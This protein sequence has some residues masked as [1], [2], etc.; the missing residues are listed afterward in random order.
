MPPSSTVRSVAWR[1]SIEGDEIVVQK[2][3]AIGRKAKST[4]E[5]VTP[6]LRAINAA[7]E[8]LKDSLSEAADHAGI[9][10]SAL[11]ALGPTGL[12]AAAA[13]G[14]LALAAHEAFSQTRE[15]E[16]FA[17]TVEKVA[18]RLR[19]GVEAYQEISQG[20][21]AFNIDQGQVDAGLQQL[22]GSIDQFVAGVSGGRGMSR[23]FKDLGLTREQLAGAGSLEAQLNL[24]AD[25]LSRV[26]NANVREGL[27]DRLG[28][29]DLLPMLQE[30][31]AGIDRLRQSA[32]AAG[33][34]M[35]A[36]LVRQGAEANRQIEDLDRKVETR[37]HSSFVGLSPVL[38]GLK[39]LL[40]DMA[41]TVGDMVQSLL[42]VDSKS[43]DFMR[44][45][46][47]PLN[48]TI[49]K[50]QPL[51]DEANRRGQNDATAARARSILS[52]ALA[53]RDA[54]M[55]EIRKRVLDSQQ[56]SPENLAA[57][58][59]VLG[60]SN[61]P[62]LPPSV[63]DEQLNAKLEEAQAKADSLA[64]RRQQAI[65]QLAARAQSAANDRV[66]AEDAA[67]VEILRNKAGYYAALF[68]QSDD[69]RDG[70]IASIKAEEQV[71]LD[72]LSKQRVE[73][74]NLKKTFDDLGKTMPGYQKALDDIAA[75]EARV[76][77]SSQDRV[78]A[79]AMENQ[80]RRVS[81]AREAAGALS[82]L[83]DR[84]NGPLKEALQNVGATELDSFTE[85]LV[86]IVTN[87]KD[88]GRAITDMVTSII[89]DFARLALQR[90]VE[91]P[92]AG[93]LDA[94]ISGMFKG[95]GHAPGG[96]VRAGVTYPV[97]ERGGMPE[98][99]FTPA[100]D[101]YVLSS[102]SS[103]DNIVRLV[104]QR[105][106]AGA[107]VIAPSAPPKVEVHNHGEPMD[108]SQ[109]YDAP[110]NTTR[111][112]LKKQLGDANSA[113]V[114]RGDQDAAMNDRYGVKPLPRRRN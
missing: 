25:A 74:T 37:L 28:V 41:G 98:T 13:L 72:S 22:K 19:L 96:G 17:D 48:E 87:A 80:A 21:R 99:Y 111:I 110:T 84:V 63:E 69:A 88:A 26:Q 14:G 102:P 33:L 12:I 47:G 66:A 114:R 71:Q 62:I 97:N 103:L 81:I 23:V 58:N 60:R 6:G 31:S 107:T 86:S 4:T 27:A 77:S 67:D 7:S 89:A 78:E 9:F 43:I 38:L 24:I 65:D 95:P 105:I 36:T 35:E 79:A 8:D 68:K 76:R 30:G 10:G 104:S 61:V 29:K 93:A 70:Q 113:A 101:G 46:L 34:V 108:V 3:D 90:S 91:A 106:P 73:L 82:Q 16:Q 49:D 112:D 1:L 75:A 51:V 55:A 92:L 100:G 44:R 50:F 42:K 54:I 2:M 85:N 83:V 40:A 94:A 56:S 52:N 18:G 45:Q 32:Q 15:A 5:Q 59:M 57:K 109:S 53:Q 39:G 11:S 20:A 64:Q